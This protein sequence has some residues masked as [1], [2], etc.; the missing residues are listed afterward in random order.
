MR[1]RY[2]VLGL[3]FL[4]SIITYLDRVCI[5]VAGP[6]IQKDLSITP[7]MWGWVMG[8]FTLAYALFEIPTG[9]LGD[10]IGTRRVLTRIVL[11]WSA[12]TTLTGMVS[13]YSTLLV[14]RFL[15]GVGEAGAYPNSS[16]S[17]H[18]WFPATERARAQGTVFMASRI[19]GALAPLLVVP[20]QFHYGWR[21]SFWCFGGLGVL[22][23]V[24]WY[25]FYRDNP[26]EIRGLSGEDL[27]LANDTPRPQ[28]K[29]MPLKAALRNGNV[30]AIMLMYH[31]YCWGSHFYI[32]WLHTY[33]E[34]GRG[35]S[36]Q[37]M[38]LFSMFPFILGAFAN[39]FGGFASDALAR[40]FGLK[41]GRRIAGSLGLSLSGMFLLATALTPNRI[42]AVVFLALGYGSM[43]FMVA[44][45]WAVCLDVGQQYTGMVSGMMNTAGQLGSFLSSV[46]FGYLVVYLHSYNTPIILLATMVL[47]SALLFLRINATSQLHPAPEAEL[48]R[49]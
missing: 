8:T 21:A 31:T 34:K 6:R 37:Q 26:T 44:S 4:L 11:W 15:F 32:S 14:T 17:I 16:A 13:G 3:L 48:T 39:I 41:W 2:R 23:A 29:R 43:D 5:S 35:F 40:K 36:E 38:G 28:H 25:A 47:I 24:L 46:V 10:R 12:F 9:A 33:L 42:A 49:V 20:I 22:W 45:A 7:P 19:G 27:A 30:W 1:Y 18:R